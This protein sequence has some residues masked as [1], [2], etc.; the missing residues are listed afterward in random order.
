[1]NT[2]IKLFN[3]LVLLISMT[4]FVNAAEDKAHLKYR[5]ALMKATGGH[6][7]SIG[8][9]LK[10][11]LPFTNHIANHAEGIA[12]NSELMADTFEKKI[13]QGR[14]DSMPAIWENWSE[15]EKAAKKLGIESRKLAGI[16]KGGN[17]GQIVAQMK[18]VG[19]SC[20]GCHKN[21]RKPKEERFAR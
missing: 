8:A 6:M 5:Q 21:F 20:G 13:T 17:V 15:F 18:N 2:F 7:G 1:M 19:K 4:T 12:L 10:N 9:I 11:R 3:I 16:A 14:T